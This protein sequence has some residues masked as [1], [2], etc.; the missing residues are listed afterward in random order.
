MLPI[1]TLLNSLSKRFLPPDTPGN[2]DKGGR[3]FSDDL[4]KDSSNA[5]IIDDKDAVSVSVEAFSPKAG[6]CLGG[7]KF[8]LLGLAA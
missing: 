7:F 8:V 1:E 5:L 3:C 2:D 4:M 6:D